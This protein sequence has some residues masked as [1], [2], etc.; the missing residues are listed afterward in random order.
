VAEEGKNLKFQLS[1]LAVNSGGSNRPPGDV[2]E[3]VRLALGRRERLKIAPVPPEIPEGIVR[4]VSG[5]AG[6]EE[7]F[8]R[9][10]EEAKMHVTRVGEGALVQKL[11]EYLRG[12]GAKRI[13]L[14]KSEGL[15]RMGVVEGLGRA[16]FEARRWTE[17]TLDDVYDYDC[18]VSDVY[19]AVAETG[20]IVV[21]ADVNCGR[22]ISLVPPAYVAIVEQRNLVGDLVDLFAK[23]RSDGGGGATIITGPSKTADIEMELVVG[24]HGPGI[25][26]IFLLT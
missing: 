26:Q 9:R 10:A 2:L 1:N 7:M 13:A 17:M 8:V 20:S 14:P 22:A 18:G 4:L 19:A 23:M 25:V 16:G 21:R 12:L 24:V 15:E 3:R 6:L 5:G 11:A